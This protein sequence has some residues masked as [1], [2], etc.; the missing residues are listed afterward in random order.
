[1]NI[2]HE[3]V[4]R[5]RRK[6]LRSHYQR[7]EFEE[8]VR[9]E[10]EGKLTSEEIKSCEWLKMDFLQAREQSLRAQAQ[11][12]E[13]YRTHIQNEELP[14]SIKVF[15]DLHNFDEI[16]ANLSTLETSVSNQPQGQ[17]DKT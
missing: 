8:K 1:M 10:I 11:Y 15:Q 6:F 3:A 2:S 16:D 14:E 7:I 12:M 13:F 9:S 17:E 4:R 5:E